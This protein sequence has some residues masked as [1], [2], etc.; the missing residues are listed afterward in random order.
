MTSFL[1]GFVALMTM[2]SSANI[3]NDYRNE[4]A[5]WQQHRDKGL[6]SPD[7]W[8]TLVGLFWLQPG[9]NTIG[10]GEGNDFVLPAGSAPSAVARIRLD[11]GTVT[12]TNLSGDRLQVNH[13]PVAG[14][15]VLNYIGDNLDTVTVDR[16]SF[17]VIQRG[18][19]LALRARDKQNPVLEHFT[20][21]KYFP[22]NPE[23]R[24]EAKFIPDEH[25][26]PVPNILGE[27]EMEISPGVVEFS[28]QGHTFHMRPIYEGKTLFFIFKDLTS[29]TETYP[30]GRMLN[31][32][33]P[34]DGKVV[35]D[36]N[37]SY[38]PPC[39]FTPYATC[40][41]P[42]K[43]NVLGVRIEAGELRYGNGRPE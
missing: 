35:L 20:G 9:D 13:K 6:R 3:P 34:V 10:S 41:L 4:I 24:I 36:F 15:V 22:V 2:A 1:I 26:I 33:L 11:D 17:F 25:K 30:A 32:P 12:L 14:P 23:Y 39:T 16:I 5:A 31:T 7:G 21:M 28:L 42:P 37:R 8:L 19:R 18:E 43:E 27:T 40:P 29:K 38:T